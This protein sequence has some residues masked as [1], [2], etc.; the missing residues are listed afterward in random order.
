MKRGN[1]A[2]V[3]VLVL[4]VAALGAFSMFSILNPSGAAQT[5]PVVM[6]GG[7]MS[8][9][10]TGQQC[11]RTGVAYF[12]PAAHVASGPKCHIAYLDGYQAVIEQCPMEVNV[13][14]DLSTCKEANRVYVG[15]GCQSTVCCYTMS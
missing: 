3:L 14:L 15:N 5:Q 9:V 13:P 7:G 2:V 1:T 11:C 10:P 12:S 6:P 4:V 8:N